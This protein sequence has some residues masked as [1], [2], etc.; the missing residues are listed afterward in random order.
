MDISTLALYLQINFWVLN[1][2]N[3]RKERKKVKITEKYLDKY[4]AHLKMVYSEWEVENDEW[5]DKTEKA[6]DKV[7]VEI[8]DA[9][10][11]QPYRELV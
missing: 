2:K 3:Y 6:I 7:V 4:I 5:L 8:E 9:D 10:S 11:F 1:G